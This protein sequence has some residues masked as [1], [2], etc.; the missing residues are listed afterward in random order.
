MSVNT[1]VALAAL[2]SALAECGAATG[3]K[4]KAVLDAKASEKFDAVSG[5]AISQS[6]GSGRSVSFFGAGASS[7]PTAGDMV[8]VY[9]YLRELYD[10]A[11]VALG[12]PQTDIAIETQMETYLRPVTGYVNDWRF[13]AR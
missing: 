5:G 11:L 2:R 9:I 4:L 3:K 7:D 6:S 13:A 10:R 8:E 12:A 1:R